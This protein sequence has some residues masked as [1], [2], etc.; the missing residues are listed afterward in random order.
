MG[1]RVREWKGTGDVDRKIHLLSHLPRLLGPLAT[2]WY[3]SGHTPLWIAGLE[4][5]QAC[6]YIGYVYEDS[7]SH[8][9]K[10]LLF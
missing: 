6:R 4:F 5:S 2:A 1:K 3:R 8:Q 7:F 9:E 10:M